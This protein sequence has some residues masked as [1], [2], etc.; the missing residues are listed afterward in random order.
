MIWDV[1]YEQEFL[2]CALTHWVENQISTSFFSSQSQ[3]FQRRATSGTENQVEGD[4][5]AAAFSL[6]L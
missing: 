4:A 1:I 6:P 3:T 2:T 5:F